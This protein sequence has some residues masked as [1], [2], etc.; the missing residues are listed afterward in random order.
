M[1][2]NL[3]ELCNCM[4]QS[5]STLRHTWKS[6]NLFQVE[7]EHLSHDVSQEV[8]QYTFV[9]DELCQRLYT[10]VQLLVPEINGINAAALS[11][12]SQLIDCERPAQVA[13]DALIDRTAAWKADQD[14][15]RLRRQASQAMFQNSVHAYPAAAGRLHAQNASFLRQWHKSKK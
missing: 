3:E 5:E 13:A 11:L 15:I 7:C 9:M 2:N 4:D 10:Q 1:I 6:L 8:S 14:N 12:I